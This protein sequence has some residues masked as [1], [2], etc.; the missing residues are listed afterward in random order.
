MQDALLTAF[1]AAH[2]RFDTAEGE[3]LLMV[4]LPNP[5]LAA[6]LRD[7]GA[8]CTVVLTAFN[9]QGCRQNAVANRETQGMLLRDI[10]YN[11]ACDACRDAMKTLAANGQ[12]KRVS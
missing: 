8:D 7:R 1:R 12:L 2:Y 6:L 11:R 9:P 3:L 5:A 4:D 10:R